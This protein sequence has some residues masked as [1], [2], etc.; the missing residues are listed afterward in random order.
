MVQGR[1]SLDRVMR[2]IVRRDWRSVDRRVVVAFVLRNLRG[3]VGG[4]LWRVGLM[5]RSGGILRYRRVVRV[6][7]GF[8][9]VGMTA[10]VGVGRLGVGVI[11][12]GQIVRDVMDV[13]G[14]IVGRGVELKRG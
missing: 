2:L 11:G 10:T 1:V 9:V 3:I 4:I 13:V 14:R 7:Q 6:V 5:S 12:W 8:V